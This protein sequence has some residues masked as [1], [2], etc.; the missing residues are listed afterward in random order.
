MKILHIIT[1]L[2]RG[3][4]AEDVLLLCCRLTDNDTRH[5]IVHGS[6]H[7]A[8]QRLIDEARGRG[9]TFHCLPSLRRAVHPFHDVSAFVGM[10]SLLRQE[11]PDIVHTHTSKAGILGRWAAWLYRIVSRRPMHI[12]HTTHGHIFYGYFSRF[13]SL[14]FVIAERLSAPRADRIIVLTTT[15][16]DEHL[17]RSIGRLEQFAVISSGVCYETPPAAEYRERFAI[18]HGALLAG[19]VGRLDPVK[20]YAV[21]ID[22]MR[23]LLITHPGMYFILVG[24]GNE[25]AVLE[26]LARA[27]GVG[28]RCVFTGWQDEPAGF[29]G[30]M[31]IYVQPSLN[32]GMGKTI[33][34]AQLLGKPVVAS[35]VQGIAS[36]ITT[37]DNG[38]LVPPGDSAALAAAITTLADDP[39]Q[40]ARLGESA[41]SAV[42]TRDPAS[43]NFRYS[44]D[45]MIHRYAQLYRSFNTIAATRTDGIASS[46]RADA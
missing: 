44:S 22:A 9:V 33:L 39:G 32:E 5:V 43:G 28:T 16:R 21:F 20:G 12:V 46:E 36:L 27:S 35:A 2:D 23:R 31:D 13:I 3:G 10:Y 4:S 14:C 42:S 17:T 25:R 26:Q 37:G 18:P 30:A 15:E 45:E 38:I 34:S 24:D 1:R 41:R 7:F 40:R 19:S 8:P 6:T 11:C 29:I